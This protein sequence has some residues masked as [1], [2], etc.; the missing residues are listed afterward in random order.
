MGLLEA[1][2]GVILFWSRLQASPLIQTPPRRPGSFLPTFSHKAPAPVFSHPSRWGK[3]NLPFLKFSLQISLTLDLIDFLPFNAKSSPPPCSAL[4]AV[5]SRRL[6][7]LYYRWLCFLSDPGPPPDE[8]PV[9]A[10][11]LSLIQFEAL[12]EFASAP[13]SRAPTSFWHLEARQGLVFYHQRPPAAVT[14]WMVPLAPGSNAQKP[15][16]SRGSWNPD[17]ARPPSWLEF[18]RSHTASSMAKRERPG[19]PRGPSRVSDSHR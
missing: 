16:Q 4:A 18:P 19:F 1:T 3:G 7:S 2:Q 13:L 11:G 17:L 9:R 5:T 6:C 15:S 14:L 12:R 8:S 10:R